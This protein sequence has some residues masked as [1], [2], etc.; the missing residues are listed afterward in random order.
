MSARRTKVERAGKEGGQNPVQTGMSL[1]PH[2]LTERA[3]LYIVDE[4]GNHDSR[5]SPLQPSRF[6]KGKVNHIWDSEPRGKKTELKLCPGLA[7]P[8]HLLQPGDKAFPFLIQRLHRAI[9]VA[10]QADM[11]NTG[12]GQRAGKLKLPV[13]KIG[14]SQTQD[15]SKPFGNMQM[16]A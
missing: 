12:K 2:D 8:S 7:P 11:T 4:R 16:D 3:V 9:C 15:I 1:W 6:E 10:D 5:E 13:T 14:P